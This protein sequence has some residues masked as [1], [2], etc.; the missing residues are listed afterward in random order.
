MFALLSS[1]FRLLVSLRYVRNLALENL[2]LRQSTELASM[3]VPQPLDSFSQNDA[4]KPGD[5]ALQ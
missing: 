5:H 3:R 1:W 2:A 4:H